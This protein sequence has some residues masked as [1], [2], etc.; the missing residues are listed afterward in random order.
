MLTL[1]RN[2][3]S[4]NYIKAL[5]WLL[6]FSGS[7]GLK[8]QNDIN[9]EIKQ[10]YPL[11]ICGDESRQRVVLVIDSDEIFPDDSLYGFDFQIDYNPELLKFHSPL[12]IGTLAEYFDY[13][14]V[15][16]SDTGSLRGFAVN[17]SQQ[18]VYGSKPLIAF[19]GDYLSDCPDTAYV[20]FRYFEFTDEFTRGVNEMKDFVLDV[21][22]PD[23]QERELKLTAEKDS[24]FFDNEQKRNSVDLTMDIMPESRVDAFGVYVEK[25]SDLN[26]KIKF[27]VD[28]FDLL[29]GNIEYVSVSES[30][31]YK[32]YRFK[33]KENL[34]SEKILRLHFENISNEKFSKMVTIA[35]TEYDYCS[36][37]TR[38]N[39]DSIL[40]RYDNVSAVKEKIDKN[41]IA[42]YSEREK[43]IKINADKSLNKVSLYGINGKNI[44]RYKIENKLFFN[45]DVEMLS[46]GVYLI[47]TDFSDGKRRV[48]KI[49]IN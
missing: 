13:K 36:C 14:D 8:A 12:F 11:D 35:P 19:W 25:E 20:N 26:Q 29:S 30:H 21:N 1:L 18:T 45:I 49:Y 43:S 24:L 42:Y 41:S 48:D 32:I 4:S 2:S 38:Y 47:I 44:F 15:V 40:I 31:R 16:F 7:R 28:T 3:L 33:V 23:K 39:G 10:F 6:I 34:V 9:L 37:V 27:E 17:L 46:R 22:I 5:L